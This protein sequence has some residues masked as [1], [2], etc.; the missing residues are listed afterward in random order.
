MAAGVSISIPPA[1][2]RGSILV[3]SGLL[4]VLLPVCLPVEALVFMGL[5]E[6][7]PGTTEVVTTADGCD[8]TVKL[9]LFVKASLDADA[10]GANESKTRDV[11]AGERLADVETGSDSHKLLAELGTVMGSR[12]SLLCPLFCRLSTGDPTLRID[13]G[14]GQAD[15]RDV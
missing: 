8:D 2:K 7:L 1:G 13:G 9:I 12:S 14:H 4:D 11:S 5:S 10:E 15:V 3:V 6:L